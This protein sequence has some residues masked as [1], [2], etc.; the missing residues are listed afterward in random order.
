MDG[1]NHD[2]RSMESSRLEISRG[3]DQK[4]EINTGKADRLHHN[5]HGRSSIKMGG[6]NHE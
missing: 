4:E 1:Q 6:Q 3:G 5:Y 2:R